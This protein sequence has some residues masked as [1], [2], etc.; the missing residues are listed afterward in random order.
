M[1]T[2]PENQICAN[3]GHDERIHQPDCFNCA[4]EFF[5]AALPKTEP[6]GRAPEEWKDRFN[7]NFG[8]P[9]S[10]HD[11]NYAATVFRNELFEFITAEL[12]RYGE[13][14]YE[15]GWKSMTTDVAAVYG[16]EAGRSSILA[17]LKEKVGKMKQFPGMGFQWPYQ[18]LTGGDYYACDFCG[19]MG[20]CEC[21]KGFHKK[22]DDIL[23][24]LDG[25]MKQN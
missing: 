6:A 14:R 5:L 10:E 9:F 8:F 3:C 17:E 4:C 23:A 21:Y 22:L 13:E 19:A 18:H 11:G 25:K 2:Q 12:Q 20:E 7:D 15:E 1:T 24:L 16:F